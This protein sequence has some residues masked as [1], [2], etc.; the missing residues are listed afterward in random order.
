[1]SP[2]FK[3][4]REVNF[5]FAPLDAHLD[6]VPVRRHKP[7][8]WCQSPVWPLPRWPFQDPIV[9]TLY[10][11]H[12]GHGWGAQTNHRKSKGALSPGLATGL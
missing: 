3:G 7:T 11:G 6:S 8:P 5:S 12:R 2:G 4:Q 10:V 1:M 9:P